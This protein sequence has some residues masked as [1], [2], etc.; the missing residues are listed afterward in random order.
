MKF[1]QV[2]KASVILAVFIIYYY[3]IYWYFELA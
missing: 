1:K 3:S 2:W